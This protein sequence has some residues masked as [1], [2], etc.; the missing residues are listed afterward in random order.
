M[1][2]YIELTLEERVKIQQRLESGDNLRAIG[3]VGVLRS[4][5]RRGVACA[6]VQ[7]ARPICTSLDVYNDYWR[8]A[9]A[10]T[11]TIN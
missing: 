8:L 1:R 5:W 7:T 11:G 3:R 10:S 9:E 4:R 2:R 6:S